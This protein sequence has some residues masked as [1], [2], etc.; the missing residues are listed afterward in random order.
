MYERR[1][2]NFSGLGGGFAPRHLSRY[3]SPVDA[4]ITKEQ[5]MPLFLRACPSFTAKW[6]EHRAYYD[7]EDLLYIDLGEFAHHLI[8][9]HKTN[10]TE[11]LPAVFD[12]IEK[13]HI[14]G[15]AYVKEAATIGMLEAIQNVAGNNGINPEEFTCYLKPESAKWWRELNDFWNGEIQYVGANQS[16]A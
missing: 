9:L 12:V 4:M 3:A 2:L 11:E 1:S 6:E 13:L 7:N 15:E 8:E 5:V 10:Q 16:K 14:E